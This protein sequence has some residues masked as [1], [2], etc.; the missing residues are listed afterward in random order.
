MEFGLCI[1]ESY[2]IL[3][4]YRIEYFTKKEL[5][6]AYRGKLDQSTTTW[7]QG[8]RIPKRKVITAWT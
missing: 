3:G 6:E 8:E 4:L 7:I 1:A 5:L 2:Y